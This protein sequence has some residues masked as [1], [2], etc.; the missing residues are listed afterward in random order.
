MQR[1]VI[2][3]KNII[4]IDNNSDTRQDC[5][6]NVAQQAAVDYTERG[7][8]KQ[9]CQIAPHLQRRL[10]EWAHHHERK[11]QSDFLN[12]ISN[13]QWVCFKWVEPNKK[14]KEKIR[15][16]LQAQYFTEEMLR[17]VKDTYI[18]LIQDE[19]VVLTRNEKKRLLQDVLQEIFD[20]IL[21]N[22]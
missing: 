20:E 13:Y 1:L 15:L 10:H 6:E 19:L 3:F 21:T 14:L 2:D 17:Q 18:E 11:P 7:F 5:Q 4:I 22:I 8:V 16:R 12:R 9:F